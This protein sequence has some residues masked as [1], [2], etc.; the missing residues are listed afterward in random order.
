[1]DAGANKTFAV[2]GKEAST[3]V[4]HTSG[5]CVFVAVHAGPAALADK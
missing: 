5:P 4:Y 1:M 2:L 3:S